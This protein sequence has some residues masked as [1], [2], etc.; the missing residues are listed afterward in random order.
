MNENLTLNKYELEKLMNAYGFAAHDWG[1]YLDTHP[2]DA[3]AIRLHGEYS[4]KARALMAE[5]VSKYGPLRAFD[6]ARPD[7][8][9]WIENPW[10]WDREANSY[11]DLVKEAAR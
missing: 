5:Y 2:Y 11:A 10:P 7:M 9:E 3:D 4:K 1:L 8:F 6:S